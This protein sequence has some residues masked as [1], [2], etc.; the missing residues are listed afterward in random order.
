MHRTIYLE[1]WVNGLYHGSRVCV[2]LA[3]TLSKPDATHSFVI[4]KIPFRFHSNG[5]TYHRVFMLNHF[6][7]S[8]LSTA[9]KKCVRGKDISEKC[10]PKINCIRIFFPHRNSLNS[11]MSAAFSGRNQASNARGAGLVWMF[12]AFGL[13]LASFL[14]SFANCHVNQSDVCVT[15]NHKHKITVCY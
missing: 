15:L 7:P 12:C 13:L 6:F 8:H 9:K 1:T 4:H 5:E 2:C 11:L 10:S 14:I 3:V